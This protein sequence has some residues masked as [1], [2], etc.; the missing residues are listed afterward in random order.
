MSV[1]IVTSFS[2]IAVYYSIKLTY[3]NLFNQF[4]DI[5]KLGC[6]NFIGIGLQQ[7]KCLFNLYLGG[8]FG[9]HT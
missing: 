2:L 5:K 9:Y 1:H 6:F 7:V 3:Y 4:L 8:D